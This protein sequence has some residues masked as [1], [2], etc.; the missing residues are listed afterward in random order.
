MIDHSSVIYHRPLGFPRRSRRVQHIAQ[1][2][3]LTSVTKIPSLLLPSSDLYHLRP[4]LHT[5]YHFPH[6]T[7]SS[8]FLHHLF[9]TPFIPFVP[10]LIPYPLLP[11]LH[12]QHHLRL[13]L[14]QHLPQSPLRPFPT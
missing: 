3:F 10:F 4:T 1:I 14:L 5:P 2:I 9:L 6:S 13:A 11:T 12:L 7:L 8:S